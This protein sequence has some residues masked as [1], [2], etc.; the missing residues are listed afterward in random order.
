[1]LTRAGDGT[2]YVTTSFVISSS[3]CSSSSGKL[4][5][6]C[7]EKSHSLLVYSSFNVALCPMNLFFLLVLL[8]SAA[9]QITLYAPSTD[10]PC[11]NTT[12]V[13]TFTPQSQSLNPEE[14]SYIAARESF[15]H[16]AWSDWVGNGSDIGYSFTLFNAS[17]P[18][19][20]VAVGAQGYRTSLYGAGVFSA[21]DARNTTAKISGTGGLLQVASYLAGSSGTSHSHAAAQPLDFSPRWFMAHRVVDTQRL[22]KSV[23][24]SVRRQQRFIRMDVEL[25][26][27]R[28]I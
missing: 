12:F 28:T 11:G 19:I 17:L 26:S 9:A 4:R 27:R 5:R 13:R 20:G 18:S 15:I 23:D 14:Q 16:S 24:I 1:M 22:A 6:G 7:G 8:T 21:L 3:S 2:F 25:G 10:S